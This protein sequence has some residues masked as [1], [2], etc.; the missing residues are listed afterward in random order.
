MDRLTAYGRTVQE[1]VERYAAEWT[2][3][4]GTSIEAVTDPEQGH[5]QI[6]RTGWKDG[7]FIHAC[8]VHFT[9]RDQKVQLLRN[10]TDVEWDRELI[11]RGVAPD[12]IVLTFRQVGDQRPATAT[13]IPESDNAA[14]L[15]SSTPVLKS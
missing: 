4:D 13:V 7:R 10:D 8:L 15:R 3:H 14:A 11:D 6:V 5:Y 1:L 2:P 12:D 9:A